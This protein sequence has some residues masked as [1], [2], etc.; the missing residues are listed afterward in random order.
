MSKLIVL[1]NRVSLPSAGKLS[2]GG[3]A[4]ALND[5]LNENGG[6]WI[7]WNGEQHSQADSAFSFNHIQHNKIEY[8]T[9]PL[10][11]QQFKNYYCGFANQVLWPA[12]H[13]RADLISFNTDYYTTYQEVNFL[14]AQKIQEI[15]QP[16]DVIWIHDYHFLSVAK[17]CRD[18]GMQNRIGFFLHIPFAP[19]NIWKQTPMA[20]RLIRDLC[21]YDV[22]GL[23]TQ[24]D[25]QQCIRA[26]TTY[27][28]AQKI[29]DHVLSYHQR[30]ITV[31]D[32]PIGVSPQDL[33]IK[34]QNSV[35]KAFDFDNIQ[36]QKTII[37]ADRID[38]SKGILQR[39]DAIHDFLISHPEYHQRVSH[40]QI[41]CPC[42]TDIAAYRDLQQQVK[43]K[44]KL[45]NSE[46]NTAHWKAVHS[47]FDTIQ[48]DELM[49]IYYQSDICW[50]NSVYDGMNLVAK[51]YIAAQNPDNPGVLILSKYAG[52]AQQMQQAIIVDPHQPD[53]LQSALHVALNMPKHERIRRYEILMDGILRHDIDEWRD[54]FMK[55]LYHLPLPALAQ[56]KWKQRPVLQQLS[57]LTKPPK[58]V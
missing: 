13:N 8:L 41:A 1:S 30:L 27:M 43:A 19:L 37:S 4:V 28:Q 54:N 2:A 17:Y 33:K 25:Q 49:H 26:C 56:T 6:V 47:Y 22:I 32:Y 12:M 52:A 44:T 29:S 16:D 21:H 53:E 20:K 11:Q 15:S 5:A 3:L 45:I 40:L 50:V 23:Q 9:T 7:G 36:P 55:D 57:H 42:R 31:K 14:F 48:H 35:S 39:L 46:F 24:R 34:S 10:N 51:E 18:L 58:P 38:Y